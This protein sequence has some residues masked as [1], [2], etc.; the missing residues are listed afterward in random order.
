MVLYIN[1]CVRSESRTDRIAKAVLN[2]LGKE[3]TE[4]YLPD[5]NL[6]PL[7]EER[8]EK[9]SRLIEQGDYSD[10]MFNYAKQFAKADKIV[11]AAPYWDLSFP[12]VLKLY[13]EN[14]YVTGIVSEYTAEGLPHGLCN[15]S[16][17]IYVTT[18]GGPY[19]SDYSFGYIKELAE[20]YLGI[21]KTGLI[22]AEMLDVEGFDAEQIVR[23]VINSINETKS[24]LL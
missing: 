4:L 12:S 1:S 10:A 13:I 2:K 20:K 14:I 11:I 21:K 5:E 8:L 17:L 9:R 3:Y 22:K 7:S 6:Q 19:D 18:A 16:E 24:E 23:N 15:A